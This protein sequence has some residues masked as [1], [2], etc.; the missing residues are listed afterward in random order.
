M[1]SAVQL[2]NQSTAKAAEVGDIIPNRYLPPKLGAG[3][4]PI[5]EDAPE[6]KLRIS[7]L[8]PHTACSIE[9]YGIGRRF[10]PH[11]V[12]TIPL[13]PGEVAP[14]AGMKV[15]AFALDASALTRPTI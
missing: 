1:L 13:S 3:Q 8:V 12:L 7:H 10:R 15:R 11:R 5:S 2:N 4:G 6:F 14:L 9:N